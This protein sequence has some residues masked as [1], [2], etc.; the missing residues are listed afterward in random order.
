MLDTQV[1][2]YAVGPNSYA[3][4]FSVSLENGER[5]FTAWHG[6]VKSIMF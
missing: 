1:S 4:G 3:E 6:F 5:N 2:E